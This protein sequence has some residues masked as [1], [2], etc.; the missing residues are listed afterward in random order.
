MF[1]LLGC[2]FAFAPFGLEGLNC[3]IPSLRG[4]MK[5]VVSAADGD[6]PGRVS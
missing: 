2:A 4:E 1:L 5:G 3:T 6:T